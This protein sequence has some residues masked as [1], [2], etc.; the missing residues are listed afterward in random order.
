[1]GSLFG[2]D[3]VRGLANGLITAELSMQL[4]QAAAV[5][6]G[7]RRGGPE[8]ERPAAVIARDPRISGD[9]ISAAMAAGLAGAGVDVLDAGVI[10]TPAAAYLV[11]DLAADFGVMISASHNAAPDNG[12]K[13]LGF[14]GRK[15]SDEAEAEV[16]AELARASP[17]PVGAGVGRIER[18]ADAE[19]RYVAHLLSSLPCRLDGLTVV[20]D[21]AHGAAT[22]CSPRAFEDAGAK[23]VVIG[24]D[25]DG[26]NINKDYGSTHLENL[27]S[28]V[29]SHGADLGIAHDGGADRCLAVNHLGRVVDG[30]EIMF[31]LA[32]A[33]DAAGRLSDR[34]LVTTVMSNQGLKV[35]LGIVGIAVQETAVGERYVLERLRAG[36]FALGGEQS[37]HVVFSDF[38]ST[39][40]GI[41]TGLQLAAELV[42]S[43]RSLAELASVMTR[44]PQ[45]LVNV[46]GVDPAAVA[47][48]PIIQDLIRQFTA[49]LGTTGRVLVRP[50][51]TEQVLRIMVEASEPET[52]RS[53]ADEIAKAA[54]LHAPSQLGPSHAVRKGT[55]SSRAF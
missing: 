15:L 29:V 12:I 42:R 13:L 44:R 52:A 17:R 46:A 41:L 55:G 18:F 2:T 19:D 4:A 45:V 8:G 20:L 43:G 47:S 32:V 21:C 9:Y 54:R 31:I 53:I 16:E 1:M 27:Q 7:H 22:K 11:A 10:P 36:P 6:L 49:A 3:G 30:D 33:L 26:L 25:P 35:A 14:G 51:G 38:A 5:V 40:D 39:G 28:A 34:T 37:G 24:A 50:S 23:V 48:L